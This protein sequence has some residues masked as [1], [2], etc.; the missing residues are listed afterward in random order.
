M[1]E[2]IKVK[3]KEGEGAGFTIILPYFY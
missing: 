2:K 3:T 1:E